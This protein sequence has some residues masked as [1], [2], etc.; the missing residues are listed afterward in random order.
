M[1]SDVT[2]T[3]DE[4]DISEPIRDVIAIPVDFA[5]SPEVV[6]MRL[7]EAIRVTQRTAGRVGPKIFGSAWPE[8][9][10][11]WADRLAQQGRTDEEKAEDARERNR[12]RI[13]YTA[14]QVS[15]ADEALAWVERYVENEHQRKALCL[16]MYAKAVG[17]PWQAMAKR[18]GMN[19]ETAKRRKSRAIHSIIVGLVRDGVTGRSD[20]R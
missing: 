6:E 15:A 19:V 12:A 2:S 16:W 11:D 4:R 17:R 3:D 10:Y 14:A 18:R 1:V 8:Y 13:N 7:K 5:W 9:Q 20:G